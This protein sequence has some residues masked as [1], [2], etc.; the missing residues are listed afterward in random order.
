MNYSKTFLRSLTIF[1]VVFLIFSFLYS[2]SALEKQRQQEQVLLSGKTFIVENRS[3]DDIYRSLV[4]WSEGETSSYRRINEGGKEGVKG[5]GL[6]D[7]KTLTVRSY[8][9]TLKGNDDLNYE[10]EYLR[11]TSFINYQ[12]TFTVSGDQVTAVPHLMHYCRG[13]HRKADVSGILTR[14]GCRK[15]D[16]SFNDFTFKILDHFNDFYDLVEKVVNENNK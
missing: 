12:V 8:F 11:W 3:E 2:C 10:T 6:D 5:R 9:F 15:I 14:Y 1:T 13:K 7:E 4:E 16:N